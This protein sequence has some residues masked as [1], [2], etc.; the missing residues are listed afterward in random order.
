MNAVAE[1]SKTRTRK[2]WAAIINADWRKSIERIIQTGRDLIA[3]KE[4][5]P[6]GEYG[7]MFAKKEVLFSQDM[8]QRLMRIAQHPQI[9][10]PSAR[11]KLPT[12]W[13]VLKALSYLSEDDFHDAE[14]KGLIN[15]NLNLRTAQAISGAYNSTDDSPVGANAAQ[16]SLPTPTEAKEIA[17]ATNKLVAANDGH[18]YTGVSEEERQEYVQDR[19]RAFRSME[20]ID[21]FATMDVSPEEWVEITKEEPHWLIDFDPQNIDAAI[22][23]LEGLRLIMEEAPRAKQKA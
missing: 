5:L 1:I 11:T 9:S 21:L 12:S 14:E 7:K 16:R 17:R 4:Q 6:H 15:N 18:M 13:T 2:E 3:A 8:A 19:S 20:A 10:N 22:L 23:W